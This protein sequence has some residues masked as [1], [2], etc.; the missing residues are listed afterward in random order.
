MERLH[1][2]LLH[3]G[4]RSAAVVVSSLLAV[5]ASVSA[6]ASSTPAA[7]A[8]PAPAFHSDKPLD[9]PHIDKKL[10][11]NTR[12]LVKNAL[13]G[14]GSMWHA[15]LHTAEHQ[16]SVERL[17]RDNCLQLKARLSNMALFTGR[18]NPQLAEEIA[19][20]LGMPLGKCAVTNYDDG[21]VSVQLL[22]SVRGK[23]VYVMQSTS[24]PVNDSLLELILIIA[25]LRR[26]SANTVTAIMPY[27]GYKR[28]VGTVSALTQLL[29]HDLKSGIGMD[30]GDAGANR[31]RTAQGHRAG[32]QAAP[33]GVFSAIVTD[34]MGQAPVAGSALLPASLLASS[35]QGLPRPQTAATVAAEVGRTSDTPVSA[36]DVARMLE[37]AGVDRIISVELQPPGQGRVEVRAAAHA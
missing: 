7:A 28:D 30:A 27:Y 33:A 6:D 1:S 2:L 35:E 9:V 36:S 31:G 17:L 21:E 25:A 22:E 12:L 13:E 3:H 10:L 16:G 18:A 19:Y 26:A 34:L 32:A 14:D 23:D 8:S 4:L 29:Q 37:T 15:F 24:Q 20:E 5:H 11:R